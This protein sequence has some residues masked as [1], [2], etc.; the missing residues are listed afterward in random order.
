VVGA[1][2]HLEYRQMSQPRYV[3]LVMDVDENEDAWPVLACD[4]EAIAQAIADKVAP[5]RVDKIIL[6]ESSDE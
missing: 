6:I 2:A 3:Y 1:V 4:D 5:S